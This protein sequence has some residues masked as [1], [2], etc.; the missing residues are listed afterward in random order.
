MLSAVIEGCP[1][2]ARVRRRVAYHTGFRRAGLLV[3]RRPQKLGQEILHNA[4]FVFDGVGMHLRAEFEP[5]FDPLRDHP[6][7]Q[8]VLKRL[9][10]G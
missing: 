10:L 1:R 2:A 9:G 8:Q 7:F 6:R 4:D 5:L 3:S